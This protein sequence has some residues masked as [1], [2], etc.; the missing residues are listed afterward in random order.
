MATAVLHFVH[1][2]CW[3]LCAQ[4]VCGSCCGKLSPM[5]RGT[6]EGRESQKN[7]QESEANGEEKE[8][9]V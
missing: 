2:T 1:S 8:K 5:S 9:L 3:F 6:R 7:G 4:H